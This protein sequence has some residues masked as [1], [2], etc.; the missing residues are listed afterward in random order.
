MVNLDL[1]YVISE[2]KFDCFDLDV[3]A[4]DQNTAN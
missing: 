4:A 1:I 3:H 2:L